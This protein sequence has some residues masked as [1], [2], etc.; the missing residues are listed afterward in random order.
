MT[1]PAA[2]KPSQ[3][4]RF[5]DWL[6]THEHI[7]RRIAGLFLAAAALYIGAHAAVALP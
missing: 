6:D 1:R 2:R 7:E 5:G 4:D 3:L